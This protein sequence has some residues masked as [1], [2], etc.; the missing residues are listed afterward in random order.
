MQQAISALREKAL[1]AVKRIIA[2]YIVPVMLQNKALPRLRS[3]LSALA[4]SWNRNSSGKGDLQRS[5]C[6]GLAKL[7]DEANNCALT[8][9]GCQ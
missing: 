9:S 5:F 7:L 6:A 1:D 2:V 8:K 3:G 4:P